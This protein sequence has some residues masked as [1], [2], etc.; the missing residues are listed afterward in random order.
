MK[1]TPK[2]TFSYFRELIQV[3][4]RTLFLFKDSLLYYVMIINTPTNAAW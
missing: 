4:S 3:L 1:H 2:D